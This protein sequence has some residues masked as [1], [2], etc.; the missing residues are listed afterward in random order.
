MQL[1]R[2]SSFTV[3]GVILILIGIYGLAHG[4]SFQYDLGVQADRHEGVYYL[5]VG[6]LAAGGR[7]RKKELTRLRLDPYRAT[8]GTEVLEIYI[9]RIESSR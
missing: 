6:A 8:I 9:S 1:P 5:L 7:R 3:I 2:L 4:P